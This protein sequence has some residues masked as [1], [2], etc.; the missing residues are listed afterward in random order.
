[1]LTQ[2]NVFC[3]S[4]SAGFAA[5]RYVSSLSFPPAMQA[6]KAA[7]SP[8]TYWAAHAALFGFTHV[9]MFRARAKSELAEAAQ[10]VH[11]SAVCSP[12]THFANVGRADNTPRRNR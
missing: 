7:P 1:M 9:A 6:A 3:A 2:E 11:L 10:L 12:P 8:P 4:A 5:A